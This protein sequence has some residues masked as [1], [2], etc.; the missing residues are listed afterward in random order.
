[1]TP[2]GGCNWPSIILFQLEWHMAADS[3]R[4]IASDRLICFSFSLS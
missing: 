2:L 4:V 3:G 1:V